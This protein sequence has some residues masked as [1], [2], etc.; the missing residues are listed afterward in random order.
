MEVVGASG[1]KIGK[2]AD[3]V[4]SRKDGF[5]YAIISSGGVLGIGA[6]ETPV[7]L[8]A[9]EVQGSKLRI[10]ATKSDLPRW[11]EYRKDQFVELH[12]ANKPSGSATR[13]WL[14]AR[15]LSDRSERDSS[16]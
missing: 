13:H 3:I 15:C 12:P 16:F 1:E 8:K 9:M 14:M 11:P 2:V 10:G 4:R 5:I 7:S 6:K